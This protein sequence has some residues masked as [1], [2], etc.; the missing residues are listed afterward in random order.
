MAHQV[1]W[2]PTAVLD[3]QDILS[4]IADSDPTAADDF[5]RELIA[6]VE[7]LPEFP[8]SGRVVPEFGDEFIREI[9][10]KPCRIVYRLKPEEQ[11]VEIVRIWHAARGTPE[12]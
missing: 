2:S 7:R 4:Y 6:S 12:V 3:L 10:R 11:L 8:E 9:I 1:I 5:G